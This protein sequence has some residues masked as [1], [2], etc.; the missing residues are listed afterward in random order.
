MVAIDRRGNTDDSYLHLHRVGHRMAFD[1]DTLSPRERTLA[2]VVTL[3]LFAGVIVLALRKSFLGSPAIDVRSKASTP[4]AFLEGAS[5]AALVATCLRLLV[6]TR[7][8][9]C[10]RLP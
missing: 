10:D 6:W 7:S 2:S 3:F 1:L 4:R 8:P 5:H 9:V